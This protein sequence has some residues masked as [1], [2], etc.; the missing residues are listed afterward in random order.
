[1]K[2]TASS[3][4]QQYEI[5]PYLTHHISR[6]KTVRA[7]STNAQIHKNSNI[8]IDSS[9]SKLEELSKEDEDETK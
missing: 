7:I 2:D 5:S 9:S 3:H 8:Q 1:M 4:K 6:W